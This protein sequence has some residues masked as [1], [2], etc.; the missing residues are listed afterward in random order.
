MQGNSTTCT[1]TLTVVK[2]TVAST[3]LTPVTNACAGSTVTFTFT[4]LANAFR[5]GAKM[6]EALK[7]AGDPKE[8]E[9]VWQADLDAFK[10]VRAKY[11]IYP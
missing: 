5:V 6:V 2:G 11:L 8:I 4:I 1:N 3:S 7:S 9:K 10:R